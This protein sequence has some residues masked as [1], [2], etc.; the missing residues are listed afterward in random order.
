MSTSKRMPWLRPAGAVL[1]LVP[2][3][4]GPVQR[5]AEWTKTDPYMRYWFK[6]HRSACDSGDARGC[7]KAADQMLQRHGTE[8]DEVGAAS[9][10][11]KACDGGDAMGCFGLGALVDDAKAAGKDKTRATILYTKACRGGDP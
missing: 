5:P 11:E 4:C 3:A 10:Y 7:R 6:A 1:G 8:K 2:T 9:L